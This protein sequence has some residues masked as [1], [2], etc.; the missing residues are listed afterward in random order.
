AGQLDRQVAMAAAGIPAGEAAKRVRGLG[1]AKLLQTGNAGGRRYFEPYHDRVRSAVLA[2]LDSAVRVAHHRRL[3]ELLEA[4][5]GPELTPSSSAPMVPETRDGVAAPV[6]YEPLARHWYEAG[7]SSRAAYY[8][9]RAGDE[10]GR[11]LAFDRAASWY[12]RAIDLLSAIEPG[13]I[14][15]GAA[16]R[17]RGLQVRLGR[18]LTNAGRCREA[19]EAYLRAAEYAVGETT[20]ELERL[21]MEQYLRGGHLDEGF[22]ILRR[23]VGA[24]GLRLPKSRIGSLLSILTQRIWLKLRGLGFRRR[25]EDRVDSRELVKIDT[26]WS[27]SAGIA[28]AD[29]IRGFAFSVRN[30]LLS[31][32]AGEP[33]RL[34][35]ALAV[36]SIFLANRHRKNGAKAERVLALARGEAEHCGNP[37]AK[38]LVL[39]AAGMG[40]FYRGHWNSAVTELDKARAVFR[41][42][43]SDITDSPISMLLSL[44]AL[45]HLGRLRDLTRRLPELMRQAEDRGDMQ[46]T[47]NLVA[48]LSHLLAL[49]EDQP[50][51]AREQVESYFGRWRSRAFYFQHWYTFI[52][53]T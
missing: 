17:V 43:C 9:T 20:V 37:H 30:L 52:A 12:R 22:T 3:A 4:R 38:G 16:G 13:D 50:E 5:I 35:R 7:D 11:A 29:P 27:V 45:F 18:I 21:A 34:A 47:V 44:W 51:W 23:V 46:L 42:E 1:L 24:V 19:A 31:L 53:L 40:H 26:A 28:M 36:E 25:G 33:Y 32:T 14:D 8:A 6:E 2:H 39:M 41:Y 49:A 48:C 10:A 15:T